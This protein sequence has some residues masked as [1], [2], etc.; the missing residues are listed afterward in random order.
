MV[1]IDK[2]KIGDKLK[3]NTGSLRNE[4][5]TVIGF[6]KHYKGIEFI[7]DNDYESHCYLSSFDYIKQPEQPKEQP[8][9]ISMD[10]Q[11][12]TR[13]GREVRVLCVDRNHQ[14]YPVVAL[15]GDDDDVESF[16]AEGSYRAHSVSDFGFDLIE[17]NPAQDLNLDQPI[18]VRNWSTAGWVPRHFASVNNRG[19]VMCWDDGCTSFTATEKYKKSAWDYWAATKPE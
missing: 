10:K 14:D 13:D 9:K 3:Y 5:V 11:Y 8:M 2:V 19:K 7:T 15:I 4:V 18:W 16:T 1:E 17:Y 12:R 6:T